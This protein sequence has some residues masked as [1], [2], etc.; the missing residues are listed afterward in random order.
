MTPKERMTAVLE[1]RQPDDVVPTFELSYQL[2][3]EKFGRDF[4]DAREL[5]GAERDR[6]V[7][8]NAE[9]SVMIAE[10]Y[11]YSILVTD[12]EDMTRV[13]IEWG[14]DS[15]YLICGLR[16]ET[17]GTMRM[18]KGSN[19]VD[20]A[21]ELHEHPGVVHERL[22]A[23]ARN[24][25]E[26]SLRLMDSGAEGM[27]MCA[28][29]CFNSGPYLS[30]RMFGEFVA[31]YLAEIVGAYRDHGL[32]VIKHTDG[33]I[34]PILDQLVA[35]KPHALHSVDP[36]AGVDLAEVKRLVGDE[37]ALC[38]NVNCG[39]LQTGTDEEVEQDV[40]RSLRDGMPGG[41]YCFCTSNSI[42]RGMPLERYD[43]MSDLRKRYGRYDGGEAAQSK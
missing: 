9:L 3:P 17:D 10:E 4:I 16:P 13:F 12:L 8:N 42:F 5:S 7:H 43:M 37:V 25:I 41:G 1:R 28:D 30:P 14:L 15:K 34:M 27:V 2:G 6:A 31:P 38:G 19:M 35:A 21:V 32:W 18:P 26:T 33:N 23:G 20:V 24:A 39:L 40:L 36:Q 11:D 29:Y 22:R